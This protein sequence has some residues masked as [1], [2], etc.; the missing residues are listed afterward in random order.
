M[1]TYPKAGGKIVFGAFGVG[2]FPA[3][4]TDGSL[5]TLIP[6]IHYLTNPRKDQDVPHLF[7]NRFLSLHS[8]CLSVCL[9]PG[10]QGVDWM[11]VTTNSCRP[12]DEE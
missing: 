12:F 7:E 5:V 2:G 6:S 8:L 4:G 9:D 1:D 11:L 3:G 10:F